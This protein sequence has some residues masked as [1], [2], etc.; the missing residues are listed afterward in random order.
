MRYPTL[1]AP[2]VL[3]TMHFQR[4]QHKHLYRM[5][6]SQKHTLITVSVIK[7]RTPQFSSENTLNLYVQ[8]INRDT[9][10]YLI[11]DDRF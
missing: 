8:V 3:S 7:V 6:T 9:K 1:N 10:T 4:T 2:A 11:I 5:Q